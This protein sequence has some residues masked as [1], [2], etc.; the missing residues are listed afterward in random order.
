MGTKQ[1]PLLAK[2]EAKARA[3]ARAEYDLKLAI[4]EEIDLIALLKSIYLNLDVDPDQAKKVLDGFIE[5]KMD[6]ARDIVQE[7][8]EDAQGDFWVTQRNLAKELKEILG[9]EAW[10]ACK[11]LFPTLRFYWDRD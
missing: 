4:H 1:N 10:Q 5:S 2:Y 8:S 3:E 7:S 11:A 6:V 9:P